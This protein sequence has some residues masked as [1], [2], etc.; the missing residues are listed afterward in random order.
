MKYTI[1][2]ILSICALIAYILYGYEKEKVKRV[3]APAPLVEIAEIKK[4]KFGSLL[5]LRGD[6]IS[7]SKLIVRTRVAGIVEDVLVDMGDSVQGGQLLVKLD[8]T[9]AKLRLAQAQADTE[10]AQGAVDQAQITYEVAKDKYELNQKLREK[11]IISKT[12]LQKSLQDVKK[13]EVGLKISRAKKKQ[14]NINLQRAKVNLD[15]CTIR[16]PWTDKKGWISDIHISKGTLLN[17]N[18]S[19]MTIN[20]L[21]T[22]LAVGYVTE[23][24]YSRLKVGQNAKV[25]VQSSGSKIYSGNILNISP[26]F[27]ARSRQAKFQLQIDNTSAELRPGMMAT[28]SI[29]TGIRDNLT[30]VPIES[31]IYYRGI[32]GIFLY[33]DDK[34]TA[35]FKKIELGEIRDGFAEV[36]KPKNLS[37]NVVTIGNHML[38]SGRPVRISV[39]KAKTKKAK[40]APNKNKKA[41]K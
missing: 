36:T 4:G 8:D 11:K 31:T 22:I 24:D 17:N 41:K 34:K 5:K 27:D 2:L 20:D 7:K 19:V 21:D 18:G 39:A 1:P 33:N 9:E 37:G 15:N 10:V 28:I 25:N 26:S 29:N 16:S 14:S 6:L 32:Q 38:R 13:T 30:L 35:N 40:G 23:K 3:K 12:D